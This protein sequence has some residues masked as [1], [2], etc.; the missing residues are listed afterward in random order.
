MCW[1][2]GK[3]I[4]LL[5]ILV[6]QNSKFTIFLLVGVVFFCQSGR[7]PR[8][9]YFLILK[10]FMT[11]GAWRESFLLRENFHSLPSERSISSPSSS[12][13]FSFSSP[14]RWQLY[15]RRNVLVNMIPWD[16]INALMTLGHVTG[17]I[18]VLKNRT[19][20]MISLWFCCYCNNT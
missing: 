4:E 20:V 8:Y 13:L 3:M 9:I 14:L 2:L 7:R 15:Q 10:I 5:P 1:L 17:Y 16:I 6:E 11:F 19:E 12:R 18:F